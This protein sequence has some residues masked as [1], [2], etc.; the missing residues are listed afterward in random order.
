[1]AG[2]SDLNMKDREQEGRERKG[3]EE[4]KREKKR[5]K[6]RNEGVGG[7]QCG[8]SKENVIFPLPGELHVL[9]D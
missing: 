1:M 3:G 7:G 9:F 4:R 8:P 5:G 2:F 6:C